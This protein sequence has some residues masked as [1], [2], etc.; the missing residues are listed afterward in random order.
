MSIS[1]YAS[2]SIQENLEADVVAMLDNLD[3][4]A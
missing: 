3:L 1:K 2:S 4:F